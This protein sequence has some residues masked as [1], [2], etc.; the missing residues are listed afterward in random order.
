MN[1]TEDGVEYTSF[2]IIS[3]DSLLAYVN[4]YYRQVYL[5]NCVY[6]IV[7]KKM[8]NYVDDMLFET[9]EY[10]FLINMSYKQHI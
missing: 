1:V 7:D 3:I 9:E 2:T 10:Q 8:T 5:E 6:K 4:I